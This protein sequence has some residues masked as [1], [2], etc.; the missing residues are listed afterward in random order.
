MSEGASDHN[1]ILAVSAREGLGPLGLRR[2]GRSRTWID[3]HGWWLIL[4]EFQSSSWSKGSYLNV[5]FQ[6]L[7][8]VTDHV[9]FARPE[10]LSIEGK[11]FLSFDVANPEAFQAGASRLV[12]KARQAV[13]HR[14]LSHADGSEAVERIAW[15]EPE[16]TFELYDAGTA[17][18]LLGERQ[19][20]SDRFGQILAIDAH[21][22]W[23]EE[24]QIQ[25][26]VLAAMLDDKETLAAEVRRRVDQ[27]R[28]ALRM[29]LWIG[30]IGI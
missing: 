10:R 26:Q 22:S 25:T 13:E 29:P 20:A 15:A 4:I 28:T 6:H 16:N 19:A 7:W 3:D 12:E 27:A 8:R 9:A 23:L 30:Q 17:L 24:L 1:R 2:K 11:Q 5:G 18:G 14:R 21:S